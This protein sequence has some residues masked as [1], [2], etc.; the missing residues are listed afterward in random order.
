[1]T[2]ND[3]NPAL[4]AVRSAVAKD[5]DNV[6]L[7]VHLA[8][9][10]FE[11]GDAEAARGEAE[12]AL[13]KEPDNIEALRVAA[14]AADATGDAVAAT[15]YRRL[16]MALAQTVPE[17][18]EPED[19]DPG[20]VRLHAVRAKVPVGPGTIEGDVT[21]VERPAVTLADVGGMEH[22]KRRLRTAFL[23]PLENPALRRMYGMSLRGG[24]LLYGPPGCGKTFIARATAG[25]LGAR[26][27]GVGLHDILDMWLGESEK[28]LHELFESARKAAPCVLFFDEADALGRKRSQMTH[29]AGR[30]VVVQFL[31][32][33]D[34]FGS[35]NDGVFVLAATNH[36]WDIDPALR[37][38]GRF[39]RMIL[40]LPPDEPARFAILEYHLRERPV[41]VVDLAALAAAT[42]LFSGAD[43]AHL[44]ESAAESALEDSI[45]SGTPRPIEMADFEKALADIRPSTTAWLHTAR[46]FA[47]FAGEG[48]VYDD[49]LAYLRERNL[50]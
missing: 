42:D 20:V 31:A 21:E 19:E 48:G 39:D 29:S 8:S 30:S 12:A 23:G 17:N 40:V 13:A 45:A 14:Q 9:L 47:E 43:L 10:L 1:M 11:A 41:G 33:L 18:A 49:L 7:R 34:S 50:A 3:P 36:P 28:N 26:F 32:E 46:N 5:P 38:P 2:Q 44:C 27:I 16:Q 37:R 15:G 4:D 6:G 35:E 22:V 25:E 24:L